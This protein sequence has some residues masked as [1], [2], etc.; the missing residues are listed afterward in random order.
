[1]NN[2][3]LTFSLLLLQVS[4][5]PSEKEAIYGA[6]DKWAAWET[7]FPVIAAAKALEILRRQ[8]KWLRIIQVC[9]LYA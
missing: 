3:L 2:V 5:L 7:E 6:L 9:T 8:N 4:K 1:M